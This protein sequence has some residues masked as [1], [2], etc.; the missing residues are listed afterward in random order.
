MIGN[1][2]LDRIYRMNKIEKHHALIRN[3]VNPVD[4]RLHFNRARLIC[5]RAG[6]LSKKLRLYVDLGGYFLTG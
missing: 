3:P 6:R 2:D 4:P 5:N 1:K